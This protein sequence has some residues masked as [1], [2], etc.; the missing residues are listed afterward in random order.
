[1]YLYRAIDCIGDTVEFWLSERRDLLAAKRFLRRA[2]SRHG[3][4][5]RIVID[6]SRTN[7]EAIVACDAENRLSGQSPRVLVPI[8]SDRANISTTASSRIIGVLSGACGRY[9]V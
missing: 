9:R 4:P 5:K 8:R 7:Q 3:R 1:M 6:G 2:L